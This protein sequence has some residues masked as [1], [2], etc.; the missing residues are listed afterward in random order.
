MV[1]RQPILNLPDLISPGHRIPFQDASSGSE[2]PLERNPLSP[3]GWKKRESEGVGLGIVAAL[4]WSDSGR[5][6]PTTAIAIAIARPKAE[7]DCDWIYNNASVTTTRSTNTKVACHGKR[8]GRFFCGSPPREK[9]DH[10]IL[11]MADFLSRCYLCRKNLHGEDIYM[12]RCVNFGS[13]CVVSGTYA[14][15]THRNIA[16]RGEK[17]FCSTECRYQQIVSDEF[18]EK[19]GTEACRLTSDISGATSYADDRQFVTGIAAA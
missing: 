18:Q 19:C 3:M 13:V 2:S 7:S 4:E 5:R 9:R 1:P 12:Y 6:S 8:R 11:P 10:W 15:L 16:C 14:F 17:A